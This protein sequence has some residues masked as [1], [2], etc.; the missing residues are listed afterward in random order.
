MLTKH[1]YPQVLLIELNTI[2]NLIVYMLNEL[3]QSSLLHLGNAN[4]I[5]YGVLQYNL[6]MRCNWLNNSISYMNEIEIES[7]LKPME[8]PDDFKHFLANNCVEAFQIIEDSVTDLLDIHMERQT[9]HIW[10]IQ[11]YQNTSVKLM[12]EGDYRINE[13]AEKQERQ[14]TTFGRRYNHDVL[15]SAQ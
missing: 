2:T 11:P 3:S 6:D 5:A 9:W 4:H 13:W 15:R 1:S 8:L 12:N 10:S 7:I 14:R